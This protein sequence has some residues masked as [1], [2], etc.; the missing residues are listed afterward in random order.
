VHQD[1]PGVEQLAAI[2]AR[3]A[4]QIERGPEL[5][6]A[7]HGLTS[8]NEGLAR[9][10]RARILSAGDV[11]RQFL[12]GAVLNGDGPAVVK[13]VE[14]LVE[15]KDER[16]ADL[17]F[18]RMLKTTSQGLKAKLAHALVALAEQVDLPDLLKR[19]AR[20]VE[21]DAVF[22]QRAFAG[23][24]ARM[25]AKRYEGDAAAFN[26]EMKDSVAFERLR[27]YVRSA[28][29]SGDEDISCWACEFAPLFDLMIH[30]LRGSYYAGRQFDRLVHEQIDEAIDVPNRKFPY[31]DGRQDDISVRWTGYVNIPRGGKY[32]FY[33]ASDD[34]QRLWVGDT[35]LVDDW[36]YHGVV[37]KSGSIDLAEGV[38]PFK[39]EFM[40]GG[41]GAEIRVYWDGPGI[42]KQII[43][44]S[45]FL[46]TPWK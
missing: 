15:L 30:G 3:I 8:S 10:A 19:C 13:A 44:K 17:V 14:L 24:A 37:E 46:T 23:V 9:A 4:E 16:V 29:Y 20:A 33:S 43:P 7:I 27:E 6:L 28:L 2:E 41:G 42:A 21:D 22:Q 1:D 26:R 34:G 39:V 31:P 32:T 36:T 25:V 5:S 45:A 40:Q 11:G 38:Y 12:V 35:Q 18:E